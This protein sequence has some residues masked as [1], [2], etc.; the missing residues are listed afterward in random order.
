MSTALNKKLRR[1]LVPAAFPSL[2]PWIPSS[3]VTAAARVV[4]RALAYCGVVEVA[5]NRGMHIDRWLRWAN[6]PESLI[7]SGNGNW[8]AAFVGGVLREEGLPVPVDYASCD[9]WLPFVQADLVPT[10]GDVILYGPSPTD[11]QHIGLVVAPKLTVE[12]NR[13]W[14]GASSNNGVAVDI[15]PILR[16]DVLGYVPL[17]SFAAA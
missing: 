3:D 8:C 1:P 10:F 12:G 2:A 15:G 9:A 5:K 13:S 7:L 17:A 16:R 11:A 6:V 4:R 14:A